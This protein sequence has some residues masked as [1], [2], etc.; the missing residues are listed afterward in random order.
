[1]RTVYIKPKQFHDD[2]IIAILGKKF[3]Y[4]LWLAFILLG[5]LIYYSYQPT[6]MTSVKELI[7][8]YVVPLIIGVFSSA[9]V[10]VI[11]SKRA[12]KE[13]N[14][15][16]WAL[17][18]EVLY[19]LFWDITWYFIYIARSVSNSKYKLELTSS[20]RIRIAGK[21]KNLK[22]W[23]A[24]FEDIFSSHASDINKYV[25]NHD[26]Y[27]KEILGLGRGLQKI[28]TQIRKVNRQCFFLRTELALTRQE[29]NAILHMKNQ[30]LE[31]KRKLENTDIDKTDDVYTFALFLIAVIK[32][33]INDVEVFDDFK[34]IMTFEF[35]PEED[36]GMLIEFEELK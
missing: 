8:I 33:I 3:A 10:T 24:I 25:D 18:Q 28:L 7:S 4:S 22:E 1:M 36:D 19:K 14:K 34:E 13:S 29:S 21:S 2:G 6:T 32:T 31:V 23:F 12:I 35:I 26:F 27:D 17:R 15:K 30:I 5:V 9:I 16:L 11:F 20:E